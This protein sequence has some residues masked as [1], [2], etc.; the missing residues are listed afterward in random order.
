M[1]SEQRHLPCLTTRCQSVQPGAFV[2]N[3]CN[4]FSYWSFTFLYGGPSVCFI[5]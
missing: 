3:T 5:G 1:Y 2:E 4:P